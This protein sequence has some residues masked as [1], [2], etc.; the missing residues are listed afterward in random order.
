MTEVKMKKSSE[1]LGSLVYTR[2]DDGQVKK[3]TS[4]GLPG[5]EVTEITYDENN[6]LSKYGTTEYKYDAANNPTKEG[7]S[8]NTYNEGNE[9]EKGTGFSYS[10]DE[11]GERTKTDTRKRPR[12]DLRLRPGRQPHLSGTTQR[13]RNIRNRRQ[14]R[15]QRRRTAHIADHQRHNQLPRVGHDRRTPAD[16][17]RRHE[18]LHLWPRWSPVEQINNSTGTVKYLH[19]DQP[20]STRLL[21]VSTGKLKAR[22]PTRRTARSKTHRHGHDPARLRWAIH[23]FRHWNDLPADAQ[24]RPEYGA[25]PQPRPTCS[26]YGRT[27]F[28]YT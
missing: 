28:I 17:Q 16:P 19:H 7:S 11:L 3:T 5:A 14:L 13:R 23:Q 10:Y 24:L 20:G 9:L 27:V 25:V 18:Q 4:K 1:T 2:D 12:D 8:T 15:L 26:N 22:T 6:R 21:T